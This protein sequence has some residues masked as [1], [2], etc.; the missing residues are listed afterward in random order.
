MPASSV[1][2]PAAPQTFSGAALK[3]LRTSQNRTRPQLA[4]DA[5][6]TVDHLK[7]LET[8]LGLPS[9]GCLTRLAAALGV[10]V[11]DLFEAAR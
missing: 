1:F 8:G 7:F 2:S 9:V 3:R 10:P 4:A 5:R 11:G 6:I